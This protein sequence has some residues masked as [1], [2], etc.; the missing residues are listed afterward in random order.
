MGVS[1]RAAITPLNKAL[2][3]LSTIFLSSFAG[4]PLVNQALSAEGP[5][6]TV[7]A[8]MKV[9]ASIPVVA[10][11]DAVEA[12]GNPGGGGSSG[13]GS[14]PGK[15]GGKPPNTQQ[16]SISVTSN[17][18]GSFLVSGTK[19]EKDSNV[20][21]RVVAA[22]LTTVFLNHRSTFQGTLQFPTGKLCQHPGQLAFSA[23]D[24]RRS[25]A[26]ITGRLFSNTVTTTCPG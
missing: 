13:G 2:G 21:I 9:L 10:V 5:L 8:L 16:P 15:G 6:V 14:G 18:D 11:F 23:H 25:A 7:N 1:V 3:G 4:L 24:G 20:R 22:A 17:G 19:F 26:N 12:A